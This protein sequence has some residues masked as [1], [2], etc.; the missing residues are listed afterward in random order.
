MDDGDTLSGIFGLIMASY[1]LLFGR[2]A[3]MMVAHY[4]HDALQFAMI[5][6]MANA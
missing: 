2:V 6:I 3:S 5:Y 4:L 1:Y